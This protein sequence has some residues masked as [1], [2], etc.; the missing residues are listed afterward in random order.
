MATSV[1]DI[2]ARRQG[3]N[4]D[5]TILHEIVAPTKTI[6]LMDKLCYSVP[7]IAFKELKADNRLRPAKKR[8]RYLSVEEEQQLFVALDPSKTKNDEVKQERTEMRDLVIVLIDTGARYGEIATLKWSDVDL[9]G[10]H[11]YRPKVK[12]ESLIPVSDRVHEC[13]KRRL[14]SKRKDQVYAFEDSTKTTHRKYAPKAFKDACKR[15]EIPNVSLHTLRKTFASRMVQ[16]GLNVYDT[17]ICPAM[18]RFTTTASY[19]AFLSPSKTS[20]AA[21]KILNTS[22]D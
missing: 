1:A 4:S 20:Q 15:A 14:E 11:I 7:V 5:A 22:Q 2:I 13:L 17:T 16:G 9:A 6:K 3:E 21:L 19:Y 18:P 12:N 8:L 10:R